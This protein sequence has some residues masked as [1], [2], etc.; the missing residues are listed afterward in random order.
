MIAGIPIE[1]VKDVFK[2]HWYWK[3]YN[4]PDD[5]E[6]AR[7]RRELK[8]ILERRKADAKAK[9]PKLGLDRGKLGSPK[10]SGEVRTVPLAVYCSTLWRSGIWPQASLLCSRTGSWVGFLGDPYNVLG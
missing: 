9:T 7:V 10:I 3:R 5:S 4:S 8:A 6:T 2:V 1:M